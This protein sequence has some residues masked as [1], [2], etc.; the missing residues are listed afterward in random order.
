MKNP[1]MFNVYYFKKLAST[2]DKAK[3]LN[4]NCVVIAEIQTKGRGR[5][6]RRWSSSK[7]G[8]WMSIVLKLRIRNPKK[9][10]FITSIIVHKVI[11]TIFGLETKIK[12]PNDIVFNGKKLC[13]ILTETIFKGKHI[14]K[15][16]IGIG[17]NVNNELP[18][19]LRKKAIS[20]KEI[21]N[22]KININQIA[23]EILKEFP[24]QY[25]KIIMKD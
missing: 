3:K 13:G 25:K 5:F 14:A 22:K 4:E 10:T 2:N 8:L 23:N 17:L 9:I 20:L 18:A 15:M 6:N 16:I 21:I 19:E 11:E 12:W 7:G 1:T 24:V